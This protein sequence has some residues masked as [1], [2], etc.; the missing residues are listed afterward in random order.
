MTTPILDRP[1]RMHFRLE[2]LAHLG[3]GLVLFA[4]TGQGWGLFA[5]LL[6][7]PDL[8]MV[9]YL[10]GPR[11]GARLY[12]LGHSFVGPA[13]LLAAGWAWGAELALALGAIWW[14]HIGADR[15]LGYGLK[16]ETGFAHTHLS[17]Q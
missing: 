2:G 10:A 1:Q 9:G 17:S 12:N 7:V 8:S 15:L 13:L 16:S 11:P 4:G 3:L 14:S 6:L 5:A